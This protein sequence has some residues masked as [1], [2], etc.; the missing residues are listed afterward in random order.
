LNVGAVDLLLYDMKYL[1]KQLTFIGIMEIKYIKTD[2]A[3]ETLIFPFFSRVESEREEEN[4]TLLF[5][6]MD[7]AKRHPY[8]WN[9]L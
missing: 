7:V 5:S 8:P 2:I 4:S 9:R 3:L 1:N 6:S